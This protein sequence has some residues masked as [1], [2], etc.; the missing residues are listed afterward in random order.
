[1]RKR[2]LKLLILVTT[3][4]FP[5]ALVA[6]KGGSAKGA[7]TSDPVAGK[8]IF[9]KN[10]A[11]CHNAEKPGRKI[12][13]SMQGILKGKELPMSHKPSTEANVRLQIDKGNPAKGMPAFG[14]KLDKAQVESLVAYLKTL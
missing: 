2:W 4:V 14:T 3:V 1:M 9:Q 7:S 5:L 12:G 6:Q 10:C 8:A 11:L 13:P